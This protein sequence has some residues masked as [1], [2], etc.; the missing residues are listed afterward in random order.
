MPSFFDNCIDLICLCRVGLDSENS[1][2]VSKQI[3]PAWLLIVSRSK[4][5]IGIKAIRELNSDRRINEW[6]VFILH[7]SKTI[8]NMNC[9]C[10]LDNQGFA[11]RRAPTA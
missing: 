8:L 7:S 3:V 9:E 2:L 6:L 5:F 10:R 1:S 11:D 4:R